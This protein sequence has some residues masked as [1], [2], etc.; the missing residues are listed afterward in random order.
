MIELSVVIVTYGKV[1]QLRVCLE[2]L[3][4]QTQSPADFEVIVVLPELANATSEVLT[5]VSTPYKLQTIQQRTPFK[6]AVEVAAGRFCLFLVNDIIAHPSLVAEHLR[7]QREYQGVVGLGQTILKLRN[8]PDAFAR[9][10]VKEHRDHY[11]QLN[12]GR[13]PSFVDC[14]SRNLSIPRAAVRQAGGFP[15]GLRES[16]SIELGYCLERQGLSFVYIPNAIGYQHDQKGFLGIATDA[17]RA[18]S[19][20]M[21]LYT[22]HPAMLPHLQL[23]AF[24][25]TS[26]IAIL[27]RRFL[28]ALRIPSRFVATTGLLLNAMWSRRWYRFVYSYC[29]WHGVRR[30]VPDR[31]TWQRLTRSPVILMYHAVGRPGE[32][33]SRY[34]LPWRR[35]ALQ[36]AWLKWRGYHVLSLEEFL[37]DRREYR[38]PAGRS[39]ILTFDDGYADNRTVAYDI[40]RHYRFPAT[41]FLVSGSVGG[42]N[43]W[44]NDDELAGRP[45]L[46]WSQ[47]RE[48]LHIGVRFGAHTQSHV[49]LTAVNLSRAKKEIEESRAD[50]ERGLGL[51]IVTF[52]YPHGEINL[53]VQAAVEGAGFVGACSCYTG[54][55]DPVVPN[56]ALRRIEVR[57]TDSFVHFALALWLGIPARSQCYGR[58]NDH[59]Q[60]D[61][62]IDAGMPDEVTGG[63]QS[64]AIYSRHS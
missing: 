58:L 51:P 17:E 34:V 36:M 55:N 47:V 28:L 3:C 15:L 5:R 57:G 53:A 38:L 11:A 18:G 4:R 37:R 54:V 27:A 29:Y 6:C 2:A 7:V 13:P 64:A 46:S 22:R 63:T 43:G 24:Y 31:D 62:R 1:E 42:N 8:H 14:W 59:A 20:S 44:D 40:L 50:L 61:P 32:P 30:S 25:D 33:P 26:R 35:L 19:A 12:Y 41:I 23:G 10:Y 60:V 56:H 48:M 21:E 49:P 52:A 16:D 45:L 39:V 9:D